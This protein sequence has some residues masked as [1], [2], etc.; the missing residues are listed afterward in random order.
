MASERQCR[1]WRSSAIKRYQSKRSDRKGELNLCHYHR[2]MWI[3][4]LSWSDS[5]AAGAPRKWFK[6]GFYVALGSFTIGEANA[7]TLGNDMC[8]WWEPNFPSSSAPTHRWAR[9]EK[10]GTQKY[11]RSSTKLNLGALKIVRHQNRN[12][13][14]LNV[15][16]N[17]P[18]HQKAHP[19]FDR[20]V[21]PFRFLL[22]FWFHFLG[23]WFLWDE[24]FMCIYRQTEAEIIESKTQNHD[25]HLHWQAPLPHPR[26][27]KLVTLVRLF[28]PGWSSQGYKFMKWKF[29][30]SL[31]VCVCVF[32]IVGF[33]DG[34]SATSIPTTLRT[35]DLGALC[36]RVCVRATVTGGPWIIHPQPGRVTAASLVT[37][38]QKLACQLFHEMATYV[39]ESVCVMCALL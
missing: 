1:Q 6:E 33:V 22:L 7:V 26:P 35:A 3:W 10:S 20:A 29:L 15:E 21:V 13:F 24:Y 9:P 23:F 8:R 38:E 27:I 19:C 2:W 18:F 32:F 12:R 39:C 14:C 16:A 11:K 28:G 5:V 30:F 25:H 37:G 34:I 4:K 31:C 17:L 36:I